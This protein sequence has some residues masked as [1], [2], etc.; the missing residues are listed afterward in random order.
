MLGLTPADWRKIADLLSDENE[1]QVLAKIGAEGERAFRATTMLF[2]ATSE[3][4]TWWEDSFATRDCDEQYT[5]SRIEQNFDQDT[6]RIVKKLRRAL[7][8]AR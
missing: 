2:N 4:L 5:D 3:S 8:T 6:L 1:S 7:S